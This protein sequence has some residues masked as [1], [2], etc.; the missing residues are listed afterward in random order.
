VTFSKSG[1]T[2][3]YRGRALQRIIRGG[4]GSNHR[5]IA[6]GEEYR[7]SGVKKDRQDRHWS[8]TGHVIADADAREE[9]ERITGRTPRT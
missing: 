3:D 4:I 2:I 6:T 9:Y 1:R 7:I 8:G 5:D